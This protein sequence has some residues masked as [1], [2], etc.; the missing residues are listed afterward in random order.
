VWID[1]ISIPPSHLITVQ[2]PFPPFDPAVALPLARP[3]RSSLP[4]DPNGGTLIVPGLSSKPL[5]SSLPAPS[6]NSIKSA[7]GSLPPTPPIRGVPGRIVA[8]R[9]TQ[10]SI[11]AA[12]FSRPRPWPA[13]L[14]VA[15]PLR[16]EDRM[17]P[18]SRPLTSSVMEMWADSPPVRDTEGRE[19][20]ARPGMCFLAHE[21]RPSWA[22]PGLR[23]FLLKVPTPPGPRI[24]PRRSAT[25]PTL[26]PRGRGRMGPEG[27]K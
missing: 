10:P 23:T 6:S 20:M 5:P 1:L 8:S 2:S 13:P 4:V 9:R 12:A 18:S 11:A 21:L 19:S 24:Q 15:V 22:G 7:P 25:S 16:R 27:G 26:S 17:G 3:S 14:G